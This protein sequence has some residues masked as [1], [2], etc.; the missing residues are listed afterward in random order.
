MFSITN[1][2]DHDVSWGEV[3]VWYYD[4]SGAQLEV[5]L[6]DGQSVT[7]RWSSTHRMLITVVRRRKNAEHQAV[8]AE[9]RHLPLDELESRAVPSRNWPGTDESSDAVPFRIR[10]R[11][12]SLRNRRR[13]FPTQSRGLG[14]ARGR[15]GRLAA[16]LEGDGHFIPPPPVPQFRPLPNPPPQA[17]EGVSRSRALTPQALPVRTRSPTLSRTRPR[18]RIRC[19]ARALALASALAHAPS[20]SHPLSR[21]AACASTIICR[22]RSP[23]R[24]CCRY[25]IS[26][27]STAGSRRR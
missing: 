12:W 10:R 21:V 25:G 20:H 4:K 15:R 16:E 11:S 13:T 8:D 24:G 5:K 19:R 23:D 22:R 2:F 9:A 7:R 26:R 6:P 1:N 27:R 17:G 3:T 18:T 14:L